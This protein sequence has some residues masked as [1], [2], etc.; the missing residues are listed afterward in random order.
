MDPH[1]IAEARSLAYHQA[2]AQRLVSDP[3]VLLAA[4][5]LARRWLAERKAP[6]AMR[7]WLELF[8]RPL[9]EIVAF[10]TEDSE[11]ARELRQSSPF[12]GTLSPKERWRVWEDV[13]QRCEASDEA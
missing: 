11:R 9:D 7:R 12:A 10:V 2:V 4:E 6:H 8:D 1:R 5:A 3:N 13:R